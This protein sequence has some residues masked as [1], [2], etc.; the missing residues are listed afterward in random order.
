MKYIKYS[1]KIEIAVPLLVLVFILP[2]SGYICENIIFTHLNSC[3]EK[4]SA[5]AF[6]SLRT[7]KYLRFF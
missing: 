1:E 5:D 3:S 6:N 2:V 4:T 7:I